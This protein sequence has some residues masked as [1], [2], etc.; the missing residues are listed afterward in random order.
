MSIVQLCEAAGFIRAGYYRLTDPEK[1]LAIH[2]DV[3][4]EMDKVVLECPA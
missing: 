4:D 1:A 3:P 2:M